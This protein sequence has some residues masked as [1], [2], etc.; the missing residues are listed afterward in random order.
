MSSVTIGLQ[1]VVT[2]TSSWWQRSGCSGG[3]VTSA[4]HYCW[5]CLR[6]SPATF[7]CVAR[8]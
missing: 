5:C 7:S 6:P 1:R 3:P 2:W 4:S 8:T